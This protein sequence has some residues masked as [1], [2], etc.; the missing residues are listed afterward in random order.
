MALNAESETVRQVV[1]SGGVEQLP[2]EVRR[3]LPA[4]MRLKDPAYEK[5]LSLQMMVHAAVTPKI[6]RPMIEAQIARDEAMAEALAAFAKSQ[7]GRGRKL[8]VLCGAGH[9]AYGLGMP[10]RVRRRLPGTRER[11]VLLSASGELQLSPEEK[12]IVRAIEITHEQLREIKLP[13]ADY[14][15]VKPLAPEPP[16]DQQSSPQPKSLMPREKRSQ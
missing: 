9:V 5:V 4:D 7:A 8:L 12:A 3:K 15:S 2:A 14:L 11:I 13:V 16:A 1:R 6:L 10:A